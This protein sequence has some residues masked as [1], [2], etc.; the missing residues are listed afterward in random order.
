MVPRSTLPAMVLLA[1]LAAGCLS[2]PPGGAGP[3]A[4]D[5]TTT[6]PN[7]TLALPDGPKA[8]P[9]RPDTLTSESVGEYVQAVERRYVYNTLWSGE[10]S[11]VHLSCSVED[12]HRR[13]T[14][15][16]VATASC[17]GYVNYPGVTSVNGTTHTVHGDY[18]GEDVRY[19]VDEN[20]L[21]RVT[22]DGRTRGPSTDGGTPNG[23]DTGTTAPPRAVRVSSIT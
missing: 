16:W 10:G 11:D 6:A 7:E 8:L 2:G 15:L 4:A 20:T 13:E 23:P 17:S 3:T 12:V 1:V 5:S 21:L 9:D 22:E 19:L 14:G 18:F